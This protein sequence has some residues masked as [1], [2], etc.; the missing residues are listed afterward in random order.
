M[1]FF[2]SKP[3]SPLPLNFAAPPGEVV[4]TVAPITPRAMGHTVGVTSKTMRVTLTLLRL[5]QNLLPA[6]TYVIEY[7]LHS[8]EAHADELVS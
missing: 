2:E 6:S 3:C 7:R 1:K 4:T 8:P 5:G